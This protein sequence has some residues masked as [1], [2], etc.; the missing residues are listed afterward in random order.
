LQKKDKDSRLARAF[1]HVG[2]RFAW[3]TRRSPD[4]SLR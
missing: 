1:R 3:D 4:L 2:T